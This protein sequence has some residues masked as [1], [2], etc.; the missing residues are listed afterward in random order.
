MKS[1]FF[2][3]YLCAVLNKCLVA[4]AHGGVVAP[5]HSAVVAPV[6]PRQLTKEWQEF[7]VKMAQYKIHCVNLSIK[8]CLSIVK[9]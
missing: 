4:P 2:F 9:T 6:P 1:L 5:A 7:E 3:D 8:F